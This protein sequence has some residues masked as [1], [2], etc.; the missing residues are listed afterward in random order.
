MRRDQQNP[1]DE[2][3][4]RH[5]DSE[6]ARNVYS[7]VMPTLTVVSI[8]HKYYMWLSPDVPNPE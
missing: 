1:L 5:L 2:G 6:R 8:S 7:W 4:F 3:L